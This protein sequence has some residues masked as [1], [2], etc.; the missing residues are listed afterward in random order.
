M[1]QSYK[2]SFYLKKKKLWYNCNEHLITA[3]EVQILSLE[4]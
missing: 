3:F 1:F 4:F 2:Q